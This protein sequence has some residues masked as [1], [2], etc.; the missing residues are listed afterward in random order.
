MSTWTIL[1]VPERIK[2]DARKLQEKSMPSFQQDNFKSKHGTPTTTTLTSQMRNI[3][4]FSW[5]KK[6][7]TSWQDFLSEERNCGRLDKSFKEGMSSHHCTIVGSHGSPSTMH[8]WKL[9]SAGY[10]WDE[11][12]PEEIHTKWIR[13]I[14]ILN[15]LLT[16]EFNKK[17]KPDNA[18]D[19][20]VIHGFCN[21]DNANRAIIFLTWKLTNSNYFCVPLMVKAFVAPLKKKSITRLEL[22]GCLALPDCTAL[23]KK[24]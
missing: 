3:Q 6:G 14:Q 12:L 10:S 4:I 11:I 16:Y 5:P 20:P 23:P 1:V 2:Q 24:H 7:Q 13:S 9:W 17:L 19:L 21:G 8:H 18:V 22:M 15:Q